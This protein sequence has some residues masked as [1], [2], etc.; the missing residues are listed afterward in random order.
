MNPQQQRFRS[1]FLPPA[2]RPAFDLASSEPPAVVSNIYLSE[3]PNVVSRTPQLPGAATRSDLLI[4]KAQQH[5]QQ[6][7]KYYQSKDGERARHEFDRAVDLMLEASEGPSDRPAYDARLEQ[8]VEAIHGYDLS[9]L[10]SAASVEEPQFEKAPLEDILP[11]TFPVDP[12]LKAKVREQVQ[13]TVSQLPLTVNDAVLGYIHYFSGR[14]HNTL[15]AGLRREGRYRPLIQRILD[16]EGVP[17]ELIHLA[18]A[19]SGF[20]PRAMSRKAAAGMWQFVAWRGREYGLNQNRYSDDRLDPEK[21][22]RAAARHLRDLYQKFGDWHLAIAAYDCG[23]GVIE[24]AVERTGYA[25]F[26]EMRNRRVLPLET[27]NYVPI[28]MAMTIM[29][30]NAAEYGLDGIVSDPPLE[31]DNV[32]VSS[33]TH[34]ALVADITNIPVPEL[35]DLNPSL[36]RGLAPA[37]YSLHV[38]KGT[39]SYLMAA[40]QMVPEER[41]ASWRVHKVEDG[42]TLATIGKRFRT[43]PATIAAANHILSASPA[44]GDQLLIPAA[45]HETE[46]VRTV[47]AKSSK[48]RRTAASKNHPTSTHHGRT[49]ASK[50]RVHRA[51][52][53]SEGTSKVARASR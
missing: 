3:V 27:T 32:A 45:Y 50:T 5:F 44:V 38:P 33:P 29:S 37:G 17:Q 6:G 11:M 36:L 14:G 18:Q 40:L 53:F 51:A 23:P 20:L 25:D 22:T 43:T 42:E 24:R 4:E 8:M 13:A 19:E 52:G 46:P 49:V 47:H 31:Y 35:H 21:A 7:K 15:V 1:A 26:F 10:G 48:G 34:L 39:G 2:P 30:K 12:K 41:R 9:G 28:I 16:E